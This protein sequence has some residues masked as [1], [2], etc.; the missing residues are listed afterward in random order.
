MRVWAGW[1][2]RLRFVRSRGRAMEISG[3]VAAILAASLFGFGCAGMDVVPI[4]SEGK[5]DE[6]ARGV[7]YYGSSTY[8]LVHTDNSGGLTTKILQLPDTTKKMSL[9]PYVVMATAET[10]LDFDNG[11]LTKS[12]ARFDSTAVPAA[13]VKAAEQVAIAFAKSA[14]NIA[15]AEDASR[16]VAVPYLFKFVIEGEGDH[17]EWKLK[18]GQGVGPEGKP[19]VLKLTVQSTG[20]GS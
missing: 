1:T 18:G 14:F 2:S 10:T 19:I 13:V 4:S 20:E 7:R 12:T 8:L 3:H 9:R 5:S 11:V 6:C 17:K 15:T 16:T